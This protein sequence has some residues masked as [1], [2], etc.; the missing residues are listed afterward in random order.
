MHGTFMPKHIDK[1]LEKLLKYLEGQK[2]NTIMYHFSLTLI[3]P[4][5]LSYM[6]TILIELINKNAYKL[7]QNMEELNLIRVIKKPVK[8]SL[9]RK[10][11]KTRMSNEEI[12]SQLNSIRKEWQ[13]DI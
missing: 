10:S 1:I 7:L 11:I 5:N 3:V 9:L 8:L 6:D 2:G 4:I 12:D 13:R